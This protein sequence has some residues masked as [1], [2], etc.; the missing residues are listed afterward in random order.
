MIPKII[1]YCWFGGNPLPEIAK[2]SIDSWKKFLPDYEIREWN[3]SNYDVK[4]NTYIKQAYEAKKYAFVSDYARFDILY[5]Y[6]GIYF[7]TDVEVI[8][9][10]DKLLENGSFLALEAPGAINAGLGMASPAETE[11]FKEILDLYS[12]ELFIKEDGSYNYKTVVTR[13]SELFKKY[14][15][16]SRNEMQSIRGVTIYPTEYFSPKDISTGII[17]ITGKTYTIHHYDGSWVS[18]ENRLMMAVSQRTR[19]IFGKG[20]ASDILIKLAQNTILR[21]YSILK[22]IKEKGFK[23]LMKFYLNKYILRK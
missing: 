2:K 22:R 7:D 13:V 20:K 18:D 5:Q 14:G 8:K 1:H 10:L 6:G 11:I 19:R 15:L 4:K 9:S 17:K 3:E 12:N 23:S 21:S 16:D